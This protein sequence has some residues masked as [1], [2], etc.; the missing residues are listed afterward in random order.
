MLI[1]FRVKNYL[2]YKE[3]ACLSLVPGRVQTHKD[4]VFKDEDHSRS[5]IPVLKAAFIFGANAS[6][7]SNLI[8]AMSAA[9]HFI[10]GAKR[11]A[12]KPAYF[13]LDKKSAEEPTSYI[14]EFKINSANYEFGFRMLAGVVVEEWLSEVKKNSDKNIYFRTSIGN[15][16]SEF[17]NGLDLPAKE[18]Q[19]FE[20]TQKGTKDNKLFLTECEDRNIS[21][22]IEEIKPISDALEWFEEKLRIVFPHTKQNGL[23][24]ALDRNVDFAV[25]FEKFLKIF[26]TGIGK[27][28]LTEL[29]DPEKDIYDLPAGLI[30]ELHADMDEEQENFLIASPN[31]TRYLFSVNK[32]KDLIAKKLTTVHFD[33][34]G[35]KVHFDLEDES[36]GTQRL[37][38]L[39]PGMLSVML[40]ESVLIVDEFDRSLHPDIT[41]SF[42]HSFLNNCTALKSQIVVT[43]HDLGLLRND[44]L[45][46]DEVWLTQKSSS[47]ESTLYS[48]NEFSDIRNDTDIEKGYRLGRYGGV[49]II[50][51]FSP[52][53]F[54]P[55]DISKE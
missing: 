19:F 44:L 27:L 11:R 20:F 23:E 46:K 45:R 12:T 40:S 4:H 49:P 51:N 15:G 2:S 21:S 53:D 52:E 26:D 36:D 50:S 1:R 35:N 17:E 54:F 16:A 37:L 48:L 9:Q 7:K 13:R 28:Q 29:K 42:V 33:N 43:S 55:E 3:E 34:D 39:I 25:P 6:G 5:S 14:F 8:K 41:N 24:F 18:K 10:R 38:D 32:L 31:N 22:N 30:E 47:G